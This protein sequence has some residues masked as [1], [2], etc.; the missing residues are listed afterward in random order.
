L[1]GGAKCISTYLRSLLSLKKRDDYPIY[2]MTY[3]GDY[4]FDDFLKQGAKSDDDILQY[5]TKRLMK[6]KQV[7]IGAP[8]SGCTAFLT[9]NKDGGMLLRTKL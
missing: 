1:Q 4:G 3:Y 8:D 2:S 6:G 7:E 5:V 9:E